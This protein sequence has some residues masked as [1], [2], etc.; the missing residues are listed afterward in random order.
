MHGTPTTYCAWVHG[1]PTTYCAWV[2]GTLTTC[3]A[4]YTYYGGS[5][6][7]SNRVHNTLRYRCVLLTLFRCV[8]GTLQKGGV[9][10]TLKS[11]V[12]RDTGLGH[13]LRC[14]APT[15]FLRVYLI[16]QHRGGRRD[17]FRT[18]WTLFISFLTK[19]T[20]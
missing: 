16:L 20:F 18:Y 9:L 14:A 2:H 8:Q 5:R 6:T 17:L 13:Y 3:C 19:P 7:L 1:T 15:S 11:G 10:N 4:W 12:L